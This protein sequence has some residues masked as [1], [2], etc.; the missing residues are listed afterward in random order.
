MPAAE[1]E[2]KVRLDSRTAEKVR[3]AAAGI[4]LSPAAVA[5]VM[6]TRFGE[7]GGFPFAVRAPLKPD[8]S[9]VP[10]AKLRD[11]RLVMPASWN[12]EDDDDQ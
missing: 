4:G 5:K 11:G 7:D 1:Y 3:S 12:D 9:R 2:V 8:Y 10:Q 6:L